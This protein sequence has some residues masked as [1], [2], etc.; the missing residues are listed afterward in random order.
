MGLATWPGSR[1]DIANTAVRI[2]LQE[3]GKEY[4]KER[5]LEPFAK[6]HLKG[7]VSDFFGGRCCFCGEELTPAQVNGDHLT[8]INRKDLGLDAWGRRPGLRSLQFDGSTQATGETSSS[9]VP[10]PMPPS[11][12]SACWT[13]AACTRMRRLAPRTPCPAERWR[14]PSVELSGL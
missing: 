13:F 7:E 12:T 6:K 5:D 3:M 11:D 8:P 4:D 10:A 14:S 9:N 1:S 2:F